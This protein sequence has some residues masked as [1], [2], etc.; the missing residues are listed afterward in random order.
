MARDRRAPAA[1]GRRHELGI[2]GPFGL[3]AI[4][5]TLSAG[6]ILC[7]CAMQWAISSHLGSPR[8]ASFG[9]D[10]YFNAGAFF[11]ASTPRRRAAGSTGFC[12]SPRRRADSGSCSSR[13]HLSYPILGWFRSQHVNQNWLAALTT[14]VD[15]SAYAL[16]YGP[17]R[18]YR[19]P[20]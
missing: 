4:L 9:E 20:S 18:R 19:H 15:A 2:F 10:L 13:D 12:R 16:A 17:R 8:P 11:S 14:I 5:A 1:G 3:L 7:C 6:V